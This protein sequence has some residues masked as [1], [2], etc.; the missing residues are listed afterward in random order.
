M[1]RGRFPP[2]LLRVDSTRRHSGKVT[3][4]YLSCAFDLRLIVNQPNKK[5]SM[6]LKSLASHEVQRGMWPQVCFIRS[7]TTEARSKVVVSKPNAQD[8]LVQFEGLYTSM[9]L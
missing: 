2:R 7:E 1:D 8:A 4:N 3:N 6:E 9:F 5:W